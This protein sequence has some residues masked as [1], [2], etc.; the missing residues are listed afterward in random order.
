METEIKTFQDNV[1]IIKELF[2]AY[3]SRSIYQGLNIQSKEITYLNCFKYQ[4]TCNRAFNNVLCFLN[5]DFCHYEFWSRPLRSL[6]C[7]FSTTN[8]KPN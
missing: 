4:L 1:Y 5:Y 3:F 7:G 8:Q 2:V 6:V